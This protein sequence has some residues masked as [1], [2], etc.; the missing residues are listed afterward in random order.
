M[1]SRVRG[2]GPEVCEGFKPISHLV[3]ETRDDTVVRVN[4]DDGLFK[5]SC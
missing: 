1:V 2:K 5:L 3:P 4:V